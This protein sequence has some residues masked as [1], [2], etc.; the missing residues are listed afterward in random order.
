MCMFTSFSNFALFV[1]ICQF[2]GFPL[3]CNSCTCPPPWEDRCAERKPAA[4]I[5]LWIGLLL[6]LWDLVCCSGLK[7]DFIFHIF[8]FWTLD[9][10]ECKH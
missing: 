1:F 3:W 6:Y 5:G 2:Q 9:F 8:G 4:W 7:E 10:E